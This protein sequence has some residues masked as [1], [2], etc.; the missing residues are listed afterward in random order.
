MSSIAPVH[1]RPLRPAARAL[2]VAAGLGLAACGGSSSNGVDGKTPTA[3]VGASKQA[4]D[5]ANS[6]HVAGSIAATGAPTTFDLHLVKGR[7]GQGTLS[8]NGL[9]FQL[10]RI[11]PDIYVKG[12]PAFYKKFSGAAATLLQGKW[13]KGQATSGSFSAIGPFTDLPSFVDQALSNPEKTLTKGG[14]RTI[15]GQKVIDVKD[16]T[17]GSLSVA[18]TGKPYPVQIA[19]GGT[20]GGT[21]NFDRWNA[22]VPLKAPADSVDINTLQGSG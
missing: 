21:I 7:G 9:S 4:A 18:T 2:A 11:G 16:P 19:K 12:S 14:S 5:A 20:S 10:I 1:R 17:G 3:I 6:V 15:G 8:V 22:S 13:L